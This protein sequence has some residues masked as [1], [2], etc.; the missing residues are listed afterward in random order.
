VLILREKLK[1][2]FNLRDAFAFGGLAVMTYGLYLWRP[3]V[4][5]AV[6]GFILMMAGYLM[7]DK[8]Q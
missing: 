8:K 3:W 1:N 6:C 4:A 2:F 5:F 7:G